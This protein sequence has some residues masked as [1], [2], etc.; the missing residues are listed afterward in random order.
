MTLDWYG[1]SRKPYAP[2]KEGGNSANPDLFTYIRT[3]K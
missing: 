1:A 2:Q 3:D